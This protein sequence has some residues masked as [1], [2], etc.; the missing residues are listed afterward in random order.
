MNTAIVLLNM[1][2]PDSLNAVRPFLYNLFSDRDIIPIGP[3]FL[4][5]LIAWA[6]ARKRAHHSQKNYRLIGGKTPLTEITINQAK[7]IA[8]TLHNRH[9]LQIKCEVGMRY[10][11]PRTPDTLKQMKAQGVSR[12]LGLCLYPHYSRATSGSS[13]KDFMRA[14]KELHLDGIAVEHFYNHPGYVTSLAETVQE[15]IE[16]AR[17]LHPQKNITLIYSAHS[18]PKSMIDEGDPYL[19]HLQQTIKCVEEQT[20]VKGILT[21]QSR[22][23]PVQWLEPATDTTIERLGSEKKT[24]A[25]VIV[26]ISFVSD[27]IETLYEIDMLFRGMI[28]SKD[29]AFFRTQALNTRPAFI[30]ALSQICIDRLKEAGW[31][32]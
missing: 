5:P 24:D 16:K 25:L 3:S 12:V 32:G 29:M 20:G 22:S 8:K 9:N 19:E 14:C 26:P 31:L 1:G 21:F 23:G 13:I 11:H 10:W 15:T 6:I 7:A 2:G 4:Q 30:N 17:T 27:H 28:E 18:L